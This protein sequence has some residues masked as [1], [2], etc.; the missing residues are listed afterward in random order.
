LDKYSKRGKIF[1]PD[2]FSSWEWGGGVALHCIAL[3]CI[4]LQLIHLL[5]SSQVQI[6]LGEHL[7]KRFNFSEENTEPHLFHPEMA[8]TSPVIATMN[9]SST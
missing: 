7:G 8:A 1:L 5:L 2:F 6:L 9:S 3:H 4:A